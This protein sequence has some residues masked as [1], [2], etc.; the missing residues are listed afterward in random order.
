MLRRAT[1]QEIERWDELIAT[2]PAGGEVFQSGAFADIKQNGGWLPEFWVYETSFGPVYA[3]A[4]IKNFKGIGRIIYIPRG[5]GVTNAKEW[6]E[7][8]RLNRTLK[9]QAVLVKMEPPI[10]RQKLKSLPS[11]IKKSQDVQLS[12][13]NTV[14]VNLNLTEDELWRSFRQ[15]ARRA[16]R[17]GKKENLRVENENLSSESVDKMW[18]L[19]LD[20]RNRIDKKGRDKKYMTKFWDSYIS[21]G[22]GRF[23]FVYQPDDAWP[24]AG[25]F[26]CWSGKNA[27]YKDGGSRRD[28]ARHFSHFLQWEIMK[29]LQAKGIENYDLDGTPP[30]DQLDNPNHRIASL[31]S[32]KLSFG[33][34]VTDYIGT[35]DQV[36]EPHLYARWLRYEKLLRRMAWHLFGK[37]IY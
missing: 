30:S 2:N 22:V 14:V 11:D 31:A 24:V 4:L 23:F 26:V 9:E 35:H 7:I 36:L 28:S 37:D 29:W 15:R 19:T 34:Q 6:R 33:V 12:V 27:L 3:L 20:M 5:P 8:C 10:L 16:I 32:F 21:R 17:G 13:V 18:A 25:A 1:A